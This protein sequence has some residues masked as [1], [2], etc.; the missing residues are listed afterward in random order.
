MLINL[1]D[2]S[3]SS[4]QQQP[5]YVINSKNTKPCNK[6]VFS[7]DPRFLAT[8]FD[9]SK[10]DHGLLIWDVEKAKS[11]SLINGDKDQ[12]SGDTPAE[13]PNK[14]TGSGFVG[15]CRVEDNYPYGIIN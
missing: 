9:K 12:G 14:A 1:R 7:S 11:S 5:P 10:N 15:F 2:E 6:V 8:G 3:S 13:V 4:T